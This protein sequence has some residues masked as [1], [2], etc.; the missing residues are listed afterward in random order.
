MYYRVANNQNPNA[1][2]TDRL[3]G[4]YQIIRIS[5]RKFKKW[6]KY[7]ELQEVT[8]SLLVVSQDY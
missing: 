7:L 1:S 2:Y 4:K 8:T 3:Y 5:V 6:M